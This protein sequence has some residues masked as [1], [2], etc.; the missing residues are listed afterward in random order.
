MIQVTAL[1]RVEGLRADAHRSTWGAHVEQPRLA[2]GLRRL[3][4][5]APAGGVGFRV[6]GSRFRVQ[7]LGFRGSPSLR[8]FIS[9]AQVVCR[10]VQQQLLIGSVLSVLATRTVFII[11]TK[12]FATNATTPQLVAKP[13]MS[14]QNLSPIP[15]IREFA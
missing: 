7:G 1:R 8:I 11:A 5:Q 15:T 2:R 13:S 4:A 14:G 9:T 3:R 12:R 10:R 6:W